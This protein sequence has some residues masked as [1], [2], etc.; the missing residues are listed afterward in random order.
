MDPY[1][2]QHRGDTEEFISWNTC[3]VSYQ[4]RVRLWVNSKRFEYLEALSVT[5]S[6]ANHW[7]SL[8]KA[9]ISCSHCRWGFNLVKSSLFCNR[10]W[11]T[12]VP[13]VCKFSSVNN[14]HPCLWMC[15]KRA[16]E[17]SKQCV[18]WNYLNY[19]EV[20]RLYALCKM[21]IDLRVWG[22]KGTRYG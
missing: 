9:L 18:A 13:F 8:N 7:K 17:W 22:Y 1:P 10:P 19:S 4:R 6:A 2:F 15:W 3:S 11:H 16:G 12:G 20:G 21:A 5:F 14:F